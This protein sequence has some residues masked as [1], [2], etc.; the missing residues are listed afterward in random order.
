MES[1]A[2][3]IDPVTQ[4]PLDDRVG[5]GLARLA[6]ALRSQSWKGASKNGLTPTQG[7]VVAL[8]QN[9]REGLRLP[10]LASALGV[11]AATA[12]DAVGALRR[13]GLVEKH[14]DEADRRV[15]SFELTDAGRMIALDVALW[16]AFLTEAIDTL[17][18][19]EQESLLVSLIK[20]LRHLQ[21]AGELPPQRMCVS[22]TYF[23]PNVRPE[24]RRN[25][26]V[27]AFLGTPFGNQHLRLDC[28]DQNPVTDDREASEL[29]QQFIGGPLEK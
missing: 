27:C 5:D 13:K 17:P 6:D 8:L 21:R 19:T 29:W 26:H 16:P 18:S 7:R 9:A 23:Q 10:A 28:A 25:S 12:S 22:C 14:V 2:P 1:H 24:D 20:I 11:T 3:G 4:P 15:A